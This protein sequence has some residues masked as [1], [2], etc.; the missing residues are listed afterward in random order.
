MKASKKKLLEKAGWKVGSSDEFL[1]LSTEGSAYIEL[2][3]TLCHSVKQSQMESQVR[4]CTACPIS[5]VTGII[6]EH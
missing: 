5:I 4:P 6:R 2:K 3:L 1:A